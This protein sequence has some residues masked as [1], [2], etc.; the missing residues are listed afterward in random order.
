MNQKVSYAPSVD[1]RVLILDALDL[2][3]KSVARAI[4]SEGNAAVKKLRE[5]QLQEL[6]ELKAKFY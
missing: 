4:N 6:R 3:E 2:K 5:A 1:E